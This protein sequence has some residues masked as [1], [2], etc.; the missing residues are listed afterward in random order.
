MYP[1]NW[2]GVGAKEVVRLSLRAPNESGAVSVPE[3]VAFEER[4]PPSF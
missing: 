4:T 2:M 3:S 1:V